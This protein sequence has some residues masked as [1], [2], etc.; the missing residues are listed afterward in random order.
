MTKRLSR[1][2]FLR[3]SAAAGAGTMLSAYGSP[4]G[5]HLA[6]LPA[7]AQDK[8]DL[9][10]IWWGGQLRADI[11]TQVI[12]LFQAKNP[13]VNFTYEFLSFDDYWTLLTAQAAGDG[14][15]DIMQ[16]GTTTLAEWSKKDLLHPLD[17]Y[18]TSGVIDFTN[19]PSVLQ[20]HGKVNDKIYAVSAGS[21]ANGIIADLDAFE[22]AGIDVPPD[23]WTWGDFEEVVKGLSENLGIWGF[24]SYLH[25][26]DLWRIIYSGHNIDL[27]APDGK[28]L[29]YTDDTPIV[30]HMKM[31]LRLQDE[32]FAIPHISEES[33]VNTLG[34]EAQFIVKGQC[35][36]DYLAGSN[37]LVAMWTAAGEDRHFKILPVPR[38]EGGRQGLAI[39]P[40]QYEAVTVNSANP[41]VAAMFLNFFINDVEAN[42]ILNAE[43]GVPINT[44]VLD[45]L[46]ADAAAPQKAIYD[47]LARLAEDSA[48][49]VF[50]DPLGVEDIRT[51]VYYPE[52]ADPVRYGTKSPEDAAVTLREMSNEILAEANK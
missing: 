49:F 22:R 28:S 10:F 43:R 24:G 36:M 21:N 35:A 18:I 52:F 17:E 6:A 5:S 23:T 50:P 47:Y 29:N 2:D 16:H 37:Q 41:E 8:V 11:T 12:K 31:I 4:L 34:P 38:P 26:V 44:V 51:N 32:D 30:D 14:L 13:N 45:A 48:E 46:K 25:H 27:Y 33:E 40:S 9:R 42:K 39:R 15:P 3:L 20:N 1:R 19:I 7:L